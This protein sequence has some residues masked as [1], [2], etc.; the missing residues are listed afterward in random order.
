M[1]Q[2]DEAQQATRERNARLAELTLTP[3]GA[4][5]KLFVGFAHSV[6]QIWQRREML[7]LLVS[8]EIKARYKDSA[9]GF[10][11]GLVRPLTQLLVYY[12]VLGHFL[13]A[14]RSIPEFAV[15]IFSGLT[16]YGLAS[17]MLM[18]MTGSVVG[19]A[20]LVKKVYLPREIFPLAGIGSAFFNFALQMLVLLAACLATGT[21]VFGW[22]LL[23]ALA[24]IALVVIY[25][26]AFGLALSAMNVYLRDIQYLVEVVVMLMM[27]ASPIVYS[28]TFVGTAFGEFGWPHWLV[29]VYINNPLTLAVIGFQA[30]FWEPGLPLPAAGQAPVFSHPA[31]FELR[32][33]I[34]GV[35]GLVLVFVAQRIFARLQGNF[36]Q[37]L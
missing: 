21:L 15:F 27:W 24:A 34:A 10:V 6:G 30:A 4:Q 5:G 12:L 29:E 31:Y 8:R 22:H 17:E 9:L 23:Y 18:L 3:T 26:L 35:I 1:D 32:M 2:F 13:G 14:A 16:I 11:W 19:N 33:L 20:G 28:W 36:A 37:E 25:M 7:G